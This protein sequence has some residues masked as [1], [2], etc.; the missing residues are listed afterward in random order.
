MLK[1]CGIKLNIILNAYVKNKIKG[2][3]DY[4]VRVTCVTRVVNGTARVISVVLKF[5]L[6]AY[7]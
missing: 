6:G 1:A 4:D 2:I 7:S 3:F 5:T